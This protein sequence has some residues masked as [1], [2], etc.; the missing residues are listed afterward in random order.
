MQVTFQFMHLIV[1]RIENQFD[2]LS[3]VDVFCPS[4]MKINLGV[5]PKSLF[6]FLYLHRRKLSYPREY[7]IFLKISAHSLMPDNTSMRQ[8]LGLPLVQ[9]MGW[10]PDNL[11]NR[12]SRYVHWKMC[13]KMSPFFPDQNVLTQC[14]TGIFRVNWVNIFLHSEVISNHSIEYARFFHKTVINQ[15]QCSLCIMTLLS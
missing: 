10:V 7:I 1:K 13:K 11:L 5:W 15:R 2:C 4:A 3:Y 12:C 6:S 14:S 9:V 8:W